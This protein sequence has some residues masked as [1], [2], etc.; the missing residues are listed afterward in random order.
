MFPWLAGIATSWNR[1]KFTRLA[2]HFIPEASNI[3]T[4]GTLGTVAMCFTYDAKDVSPS[5]MSLFDSYY[6]SCVFNPTEKIIMNVDLKKIMLQTPR[7]TTNKL[8]DTLPAQSDSNLYYLGNL[9]FAVAGSP[10]TTTARIGRIE[11]HYDIELDIPKPT[12]LGTTAVSPDITDF[13]VLNGWSPPVILANTLRPFSGPSDTPPEVATCTPRATSK[14][15]IV[16]SDIGGGLAQHNIQFHAEH[17]D[18]YYILASMGN[19]NTDIGACTG[20][21]VN[22]S[23]LLE[24]PLAVMGQIRYQYP[25]ITHGSIS[26]YFE[27]QFVSVSEYASSLSHTSNVTGTQSS[28]YLIATGAGLCQVF[29]PD[30]KVT[31][32]SGETVTENPSM[33]TVI[34]MGNIGTGGSSLVKTLWSTSTQKVRHRLTETQDTTLSADSSSS[35][36]SAAARPSRESKDSD[37]EDYDLALALSLSSSSHDPLAKTRLSRSTLVKK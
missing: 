29:P 32:T 7:Y 23:F 22:D 2:F 12:D 3:S 8:P 1:Y 16:Y 33:L 4:S 27:S 20:T 18:M 25:T 13:L 31:A 34:F 24:G 11:V 5:S 10:A 19:A 28:G 30:Y 21:F 35:S 17:G 37:D 14:F 36:S 9:A 15:G 6:G 26:S